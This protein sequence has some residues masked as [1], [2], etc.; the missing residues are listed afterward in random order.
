[1]YGEAILQYRIGMYG[2]LIQF[3]VYTV[4]PYY[5]I[6]YGC[7][8]ILQFVLYKVRPCYII[9]QGCNTHIV[10]FRIKYIDDDIFMHVQ[11]L[12]EDI[13]LECN[14]YSTKTGNTII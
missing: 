4:R 3:G 12:A 1:M 10:Q 11:I 2:Y 7:T 9:G 6:G 14:Y 8:A 5:K 13:A